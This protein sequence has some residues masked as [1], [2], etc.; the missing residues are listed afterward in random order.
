MAAQYIAQT[1]RPLFE[2]CTYVEHHQLL[3]GHC[4]YTVFL[5]ENWNGVGEQPKL[6]LKLEYAYHYLP[7]G[8]TGHALV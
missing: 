8:G 4:A 2:L 6:V 1:G 7:L 3:V 5:R